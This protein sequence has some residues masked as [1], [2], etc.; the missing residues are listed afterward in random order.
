MQIF[1]ESQFKNT[2]ELTK[3]GDRTVDSRDYQR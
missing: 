3:G 2:I 1:K